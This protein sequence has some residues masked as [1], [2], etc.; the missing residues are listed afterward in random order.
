MVTPPRVSRWL[1]PRKTLSQQAV[2]PRRCKPIRPRPSRARRRHAWSLDQRAASHPPTRV[3][4]SRAT[5]RTSA[6]IGQLTRRASGIAVPRGNRSTGGRP[7]ILR[8]IDVLRPRWTDRR[9]SRQV[10]RRERQ[11]GRCRTTRP[12]S[13]SCRPR[14]QTLGVR[15]GGRQSKAA[16]LSRRVDQPLRLLGRSAAIR[17]GRAPRTTA[18]SASGATPDRNRRHG[19]IPGRRPTGSRTRRTVRPIS[20]G[21]RNSRAGARP[22]IL[23][24]PALRSRARHRSDSRRPASPTSHRLSQASHNQSIRNHLGCIRTS[25]NRVIRPTHRHGLA[26]RSR[27]SP[28]PSKASVLDLTLR[29]R[30]FHGS[31]R[32]TAVRQKSSHPRLVVAMAPTGSTHRP[33]QASRRAGRKPPVR[34][35]PATTRRW[36]TTPRCDRRQPMP[37][38]RSR[39]VRR[40]GTMPRLPPG[41]VSPRPRHRARGRAWGPASRPSSVIRTGQARTSLVV[42]STAS[43]ATGRRSIKGLATGQPSGRQTIRSGPDHSPK[44]VGG[45]VAAI[46]DHAVV[47]LIWLRTARHSRQQDDGAPVAG[48][49]QSRHFTYRSSTRLLPRATRA[50]RIRTPVKLTRLCGVDTRCGQRSKLR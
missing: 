47:Y 33:K 14:R 36:R 13:R 31:R 5:G 15:P 10:H 16:S 40:M 7:S 19:R 34:T 42:R 23:D 3:R 38:R 21:G 6:A 32:A 35:R 46:D 18:C 43:Q 4:T 44:G 9:L 50:G 25:H 37:R 8:L 41:R 29:P 2:T 17:H 45:T 20:R 27:S 22:T 28:I 12:A 1:L 48:D 39:R 26:I 30:G 24:G 11:L 49:E